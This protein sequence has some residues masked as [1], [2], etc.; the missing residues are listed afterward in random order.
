MFAGAV[1]GYRG[2]GRHRRVEL[3]GWLHDAITVDVLDV[4][5]FLLLLKQGKTSSFNNKSIYLA[6]AQ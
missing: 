4:Q 6:P 3:V 5:L 1:L 2:A